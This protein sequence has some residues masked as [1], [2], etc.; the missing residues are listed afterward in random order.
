MSERPGESPHP[1]QPAPHLAPP[2]TSPKPDPMPQTG[3]QPAVSTTPCAAEP[4]E[5]EEVE[6]L[7]WDEAGDAVDIDG[8]PAAIDSDGGAT[9]L[10]L[11][12]QHAEPAAGSRSGAVLAL[13]SGGSG[14]NGVEGGF[15]SDGTPP[16]SAGS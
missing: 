8:S 14:G 3:S 10:N 11:H 9:S 13:G 16:S 6:L 5:V 2:A 4:E 7:D 12:S 15:A 1:S